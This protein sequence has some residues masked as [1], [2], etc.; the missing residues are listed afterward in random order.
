MSDSESS[1]DYDE[2][3]SSESEPEKTES[4]QSP[5]APSIRSAMRSLHREA[6]SVTSADSR[7]CACN[8]IANAAQLEK[9]MRG[10]A[11]PE[12]IASMRRLLRT[13]CKKFV[14][15]GDIERLFHPQVPV[16]G[17]EA[18]L[19]QQLA[20]M[21]A[22]EAIAQDEPDV[23]AMLSE[24]MGVDF[25][26]G[27]THRGQRRS[28]LL[29]A[30]ECSC[31][32]AL[33]WLFSLAAPTCHEPPVPLTR[34][35]RSICDLVERCR[36]YAKRISGLVDALIESGARPTEAYGLE[37][38][39]L[40][41]ALDC[42]FPRVFQPVLE[43]HVDTH[44]T[45]CLDYVEVVRHYAGD[46]DDIGT[47]RPL[48]RA[49]ARG[50]LAAVRAL[51]AK[52]ASA[53]VPTDLPVLTDLTVENQDFHDMFVALFRAGASSFGANLSNLCAFPEPYA[54]MCLSQL[55]PGSFTQGDL[56]SKG[57]DCLERGAADV[58]SQLIRL[59]MDPTIH[60]GE[61]SSI[62]EMAVEP[63]VASGIV[64]QVCVYLLPCS[65]KNMMMMPALQGAFFTIL[66][67]L[68]RVCPRLPA[69][70]RLYIF[71]FLDGL[72]LF[73]FCA[74]SDPSVEPILRNRALVY[75]EPN[76]L[77]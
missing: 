22:I 26:K 69:E 56:I 75:F 73:P 41:R 20:R 40:N 30:A 43:R 36:F 10:V 55:E 60:P 35:L 5:K 14:C 61:M 39:D 13:A 32:D 17:S 24:R 57:R 72:D 29:L 64:R 62:M 28:F 70:I 49:A 42:G 66:C 21:M 8:F 3:S 74:F 58:F 33:E 68:K 18:L 76:C 46:D 53:N 51:L 54:V 59:G 45:Q 77:E 11:E 15:C 2:Q 65:L 23:A 47:I 16:S 71:G 44:G 4:V 63:G 50:C 27:Y 19:Y 48:R 34:L 67:A 37:R 25:T 38:A 7:R 31:P 12:L 52:G 9:R 6:V 1:S